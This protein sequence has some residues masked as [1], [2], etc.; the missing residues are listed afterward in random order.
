M[1][2]G[3]QGICP[4]CDTRG[5]FFD[6]ALELAKVNGRGHMDTLGDSGGIRL[7]EKYTPIDWRAAW[8][9]EAEK[10]KWLVEPVLEEGTLC[11]LYG[12]PGDGK[13][14]VTL[15]LTL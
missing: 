6:V 2:L 9:E 10:I 1:P 12:R 8:K 5:A 7:A 14:L 13:S 4:F 3:P 11:A 15:W